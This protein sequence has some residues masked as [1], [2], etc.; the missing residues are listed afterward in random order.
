ME[1]LD[2]KELSRLLR[3]W[4]APAAP[5]SLGRRVLPHRESSMPWWKWLFTGTIRVPVP[6]GFVAVLLVAAWI[7]LSETRWPASPAAAR[8][9]APVSLAD[10]QAVPQ[11]EPKSVGGQQ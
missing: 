4:E 11:L 3:T 7:Y 2:E 8:P 5:A 6:V 9:S 10:F 1:P